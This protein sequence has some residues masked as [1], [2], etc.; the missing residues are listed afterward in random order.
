MVHGSDAGEGAPGIVERL[1]DGRLGAMGAVLNTILAPA[2]L[3]FRTLVAARDRAYRLGVFRTRPAPAPA[4]SVGNLTVGGTGKTPLVRWVVKQLLERGRTPGILHGGYS[5]DEPALHRHWFPALPVVA[6]R[7]RV[8]AAERAVE[9]GADVLV[10]D[11]GFQHRR[12]GR[13]LDV[14]LV[15]AETWTPSP[16][17]LPRGPYREPVRALDRAGVVVVTRRQADGAAAA[18]VAREIRATASS[19]VAIAYL[20]PGSWLDPG[21]RPRTDSP[22]RGVAVAGVGQPVAFFDQLR[23]RGVALT[24]TMAF[25]DHH[26]YSAE[27]AAAIRRAAGGGAVITTAKDAVKL[28]PLLPDTELWVLDQQVIFEE[29]RDTLVAAVEEALR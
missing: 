1:W 21:G 22:E 20:A 25:R 23:D 17:L 3:A 29:G 16:R 8:S 26:A 12:I 19:P 5:D 7:D 4:I 27:D 10:L 18:R 15:A 28:H 14:V 13:Q 6:R 2:E 24:D 11:D 9:A